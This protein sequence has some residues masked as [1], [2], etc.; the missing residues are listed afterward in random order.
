M[1]F[2]ENVIQIVQASKR[3]NIVLPES[4]ESRNIC[5]AAEVLQRGFADI[6]LLG[7]EDE[8]KS[9]AAKEGVNVDSA[10]FIDPKTTPMLEELV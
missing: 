4:T 1:G 9:I 6:T 8:I 3:K 5:A 7:N 10:H 2:I